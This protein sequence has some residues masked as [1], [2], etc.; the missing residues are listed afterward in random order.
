MK[1]FRSSRDSNSQNPLSQGS[2]VGSM[3]VS[4]SLAQLVLAVKQ[5]V[6]HD[7]LARMEHIPR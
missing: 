1:G 4:P 3:W 7:P 5:K 2:S 6:C